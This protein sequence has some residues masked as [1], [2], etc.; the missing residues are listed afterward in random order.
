MEYK[1]PGSDDFEQMVILQN[2][3]LASTLTSSE[4]ADGF[5]SEAFSAEKFKAIDDDLCVLICKDKNRMC[6]YLCVSSIEHNKKVPLVEAMVKRF[7]HIIYH[8]K[9]LTT[10]NIAIYGPVC[11]DKDYRGQ[12]ILLNLYNALPQ[13]LLKEH[14]ELDLYAVLISSLNQRSVNAH[15]KLGMEIIGEYEFN[16][17]TFLILAAPIK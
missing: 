4:K 6:G 16:K 12:G 13:F 7:P 2:K 5:L 17:N 3:N 1:R 15:K 10:Y 9:P 8:G 14:S 11:I